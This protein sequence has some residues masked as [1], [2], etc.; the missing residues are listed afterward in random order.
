MIP[1]ATRVTHEPTYC[2]YDQ[3]NEF[4]L[5]AFTNIA[6]TEGFVVA[7]T[8]FAL[9]LWLRR[10]MH[11]ARN[12]LATAAGV[13]VSV[14]I[15]KEVLRIPRPTDALIE[16]IGYAF[17]SGH[18]AG[19]AFLALSICHTVRTCKKPVRYSVYVICFMSA[20]AIGMSR[21]TLGVHTP[22]QVGAGYV[23]GALWAGVFV[24]LSMRKHS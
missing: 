2:Y 24:V 16:T 11:Q 9:I 18:A 7:I 5:F 19:S 12:L 6:S 15:M 8:F 22:L 1:E 21:V 23:I 4:Y 20:L 17:P 10:H 14:Q 3:M 13:M